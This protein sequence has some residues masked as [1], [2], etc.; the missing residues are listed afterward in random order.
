MC[1]SKQ[2]LEELGKSFLGNQGWT[3]FGEV[4]GVPYAFS[5]CV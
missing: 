3:L 5:V 1:W 2:S 4:V